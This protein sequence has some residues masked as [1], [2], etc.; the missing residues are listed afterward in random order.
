M[1]GPDDSD[2]EAEGAAEKGS[3]EAIAGTVSALR[4]SLPRGSAR[5]PTPLCAT[6]AHTCRHPNSIA[7]EASDQVALS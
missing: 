3:E 6:L 2:E 1:N 5:D 4:V 7:V